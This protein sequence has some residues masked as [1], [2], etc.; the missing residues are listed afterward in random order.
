MYCIKKIGV[1]FK[2]I[3]KKPAQ[4]KDVWCP[5]SCRSALDPC[6]N[7]GPSP[8]IVR[9]RLCIPWDVYHLE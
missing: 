1:G 4:T 6:E 7:Y 8:L 5:R 9:G 3:V 2:N